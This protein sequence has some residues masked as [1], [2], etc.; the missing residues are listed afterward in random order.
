MGRGSKKSYCFLLCGSD[1][2]EAR[3]RLSVIKQNSDGFKI[4]EYHLKKRGGGGSLG[5]R[6]SGKFLNEIR[7]LKYPPEVIFEAKKLSDEAF[8][9]GGSE[10]L[11]AFALKK[12]E[13]LKEVIL[14]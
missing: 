13:S 2:E 3:E 6:Q 9:G 14:N 12:Y 7:N 10:Q 4:A 11:R 1:G 5:T 8:E